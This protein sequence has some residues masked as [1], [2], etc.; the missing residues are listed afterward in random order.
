MINLYKMNIYYINPKKRCV[1][2]NNYYKENKDTFIE[3]TIN[4]DMSNQYK[5]FEK[6]L[7]KDTKKILDVGFGSGRDSLYFS[8]KYE[9]YSI[10]PVEEFCNHAKEIGLKNVYCMKVQDITFINEFDGIWACAS[11]LHIPSYELVDVLN[12]CY[13]ALTSNG[14]MYCS[15]K[16]GEFEGERQGRFFLDLIEER[17]RQYVSKTKFEILEVSITNDVRPDREEKWLNVVMRK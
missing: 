15:F 12:R 11:L 5:L 13:N 7:N 8:K 3:N 4:C 6:Y 14:I 2:M 17:F 9:V 10:D 16:F 1:M